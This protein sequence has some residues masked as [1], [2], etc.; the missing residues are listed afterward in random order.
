M[1]SCTRVLF[2]NSMAARARINIYIINRSVF[3]SETNNVMLQSNQYLIFS[4]FNY[5]FSVME[6]SL[7]FVLVFIIR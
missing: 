4:Y 6:H 5:Y 3:P 7:L 1:K 2:M